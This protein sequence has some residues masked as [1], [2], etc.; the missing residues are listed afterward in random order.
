MTTSMNF[1]SG[2][3]AP[4]RSGNWSL[5][6]TSFSI[7]DGQGSTWTATLNSVTNPTAMSGNYTAGTGA[8]GG[9]WSARKL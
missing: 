7:I 6:G 5:N 1:T 4:S 3:V 9:S 8:Q 2:N